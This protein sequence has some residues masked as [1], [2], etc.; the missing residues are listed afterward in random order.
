MEE[1]QHVLALSCTLSKGDDVSQ[2]S[3]AHPIDRVSA[4]LLTFFQTYKVFFL[5]WSSLLW[6]EVLWL[7]SGIVIG[8][9]YK[10]SDY[11]AILDGNALAYRRSHTLWHVC[12]PAAF[13]SHSL[14]RWYIFVNSRIF[15]EVGPVG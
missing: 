12:L 7:A 9:Y 14:A 15:V 5:M 11:S 6:I 13:I 1:L 4:V 8:I 3:W 10:I 2:V